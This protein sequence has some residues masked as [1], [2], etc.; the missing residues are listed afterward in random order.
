LNGALS[1]RL[2]LGLY[3]GPIGTHAL[4]FHDNARHKPGGA[5]VIGLG[6]VG[7]ITPGLLSTGV[8][9][10]LLDYALRIAQWPD[11]RFGPAGSPRAARITAL[12]VGSGAGGTAVGD[13][14]RAILRGVV[15]ANTRLV[16]A[17]LDNQVLIDRLEF[18]DVYED[19]AIAAA[20][21]LETV[22]K[23]GELAAEIS[24]PDGIIA[25]GQGG[26]RRLRREETPEWWHR[27]EIIQDNNLEKLRFIAVTER[28][29]AEETLAVGQLRLA[30][31]FIQQ[32]SKSPAINTEVAKTL[33]EMLLPNRLKQLAPREVDLVLLVDNASAAYPWELLQDR[34]SQ[35]GRPPAIAAG[36]VRQLKTPSFRPLTL[37]ATEPTA[38]VIGNPDLAG[39]E[40]FPDLPGARQEAQKV[41]TVLSSKGYKTQACIDEPAHAILSSLH[42][43]A[44]RILHLA[45]HGEH[46]FP[47]EFHQATPSAVLADEFTD[48]PATGGPGYPG[49]TNRA[50]K[51]VSGM[52]IGEDTFLTPGDVEQMRWVPELVFINCCHLGKT[53]TAG[54]GRYNLLAANLAVQFIKMGVK[55]VVAAGWAV[56]DAAAETFAESFYTHLL[57]G[58]PFGKAVRAA[59]EEIWKRF[60]T[61]NTW[62]AYQCYGDPSYQLHGDGT[63]ATTPKKA[64]HHTPAELIAELR[65]HTE[66]VRV[67]IR[68][69]HESPK[70]LDTFRLGINE[71]LK[72]IPDSHHK[73]WLERAD[74]AAALGFA[75]GEFGDY[76]TAVQWL[77]TALQAKQ[78]DCPLRAVE[79]CANFQVRLAGQQ[80]QQ[81]REAAG[82]GITE[83][84]RQRLIK[85]IN[86]AID[87]LDGIAARAPTT[88]RLSIMGSACKRLAWLPTDSNSR[89]EA[90]INIAN[91]YRQAFELSK[92]TDPYPFTN[93]GTAKLLATRLDP[94]RG[95]EWQTTLNDECQAMIQSAR[96]RNE[97]SPNFWDSVAEGD[98]K[99][100]LLLN[101]PPTTRDAADHAATSIIEAYRTA[102]QRG[103]SP[104]E[105]AS[106]R[107]HLEF[108]IAMIETQ[109][110]S[111]LGHALQSIHSA[112]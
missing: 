46:E 51:L 69:K 74:V 23:D 48:S 22:L 3:P 7:Q 105:Y 41:T 86:Q 104:R 58:E 96:E 49:G 82:K 73:I 11:E 4:F 32:A 83:D 39:W 60:P 111:P 108:V 53:E 33:F 57:E 110:D 47:L 9:D 26:Q 99:L 5:L 88:E 109:P 56:D 80:W 13:S 21:A 30:E 93:W 85:T 92:K 37:H 16:D 50:I 59:R 87:E 29:R 55:A 84:Q 103:A 64:S 90:L 75:W 62:G 42:Q 27:L 61:V 17:E 19:V 1:R 77:K 40:V 35:S 52:V 68:E 14:I 43:Q 34:W 28:A 31:S 25:E 98:C 71:Q 6:Q 15:D 65:N 102:A 79:Q 63:N 95:G 94:D 36:L 44:W 112:L 91:Y 10:A 81:L 8:R 24:W 89:M 18:L 97:K 100:V 20:D 101:E 66:W 12:L 107:E 67:Q 38:L 45:G 54:V 2:Q 72:G 106:V 70:D 78:G 76:A